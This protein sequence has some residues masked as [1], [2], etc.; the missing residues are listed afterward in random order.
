MS[1]PFRVHVEEQVK[2]AERQFRSLPQHHQSLLPNVL[3]N[4]AR[5]SQ[6]ATHNQEL[7]HAIVQNSL[8]MFENIEYGERVRLHLNI[9]YKHGLYASVQSKN[10]GTDVFYIQLPGGSTESTAVLYV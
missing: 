3:S 5:I 2:R 4:L 8:H 9:Q 7:L 10:I 6:C 1:L